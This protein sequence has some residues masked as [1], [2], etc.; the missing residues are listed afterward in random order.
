MIIDLSAPAE[1][2]SDMFK[3]LAAPESI[4]NRRPSYPPF[5]RPACDRVRHAIRCVSSCRAKVIRL[6]A[7]C[8]PSAVRRLVIA[9]GV[10]T[11]NRV[12]SAGGFAHIGKEQVVVVP[13][14]ADRNS[15]AAVERVLVIA[16]R[17]ASGSH[18]GPCVVFL[19]SLPLHAQ[20]MFLR[21]A[22]DF[23]EQATTR[24]RVSVS[25]FCNGYID[26]LPALATAAPHG[27]CIPCSRSACLR[28]FKNDQAAVSMSNRIN[29]SRHGS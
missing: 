12:G 15:S 14:L 24:L 28:F 27:S 25:Q 20:A 6:L 3:R 10:D 19:R 22:D 21:L 13:S 11:I 16:R 17:V 7:G 29:G 5:F 1:N 8:R 4:L 2:G 9:I 26:N 23:K 18:A